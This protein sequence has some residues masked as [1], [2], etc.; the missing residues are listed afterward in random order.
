MSIISKKT[1]P[2]D[3]LMIKDTFIISNKA[4]RIAS[5]AILIFFMILV[6]TPLLILLNVSLKSNQEYMLKGVYALPEN[7]LNFKNYAKAF[8]T[9]KFALGFKNTLILIGVSVPVSLLTGTM[10]AYAMGRFDFVLKKLMLLLFLVPTF[11]PAMTVTIATFTLIRNL[12]LYNTRLAGMLLYIGTDIMQIYIFLQFINQIPVA[13]DESARIDG[14]SRL[15]IYW[16]IILPQMK[17]A[18]ATGAILKVLGIYNDFFT[19]YMYMPK[20]NLKTV[21]TAL[22]SFAGDRMADWPLMSSAI[23]FVA[24]PTIVM[25]IFMQRYI[26]SGVTDGAVK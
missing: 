3:D 8:V 2:K 13:L 6:F 5:Y 17:P 15:R 16:S 1:K 22:N 21:A 9:G 7:I 12:G 19:P 24:I 25:Y 20:S 10:V 23:L 11:I 26:I 4:G 14:A 18:L